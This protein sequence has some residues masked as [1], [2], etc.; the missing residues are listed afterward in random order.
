MP[1][2]N[3]NLNE[4]WILSIVQ[5]SK[6]NHEMRLVLLTLSLPMACNLTLEHQQHP[7]A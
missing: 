3:L 7:V 4:S 6:E 1:L 2:R 5:K